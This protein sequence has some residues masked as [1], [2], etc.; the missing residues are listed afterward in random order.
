MNRGWLGFTRIPKSLYH[1]TPQG[2]TSTERRK[3]FRE[4][5]FC[6]G[7]RKLNPFSWWNLLVNIIVGEGTKPG[8]KLH[9]FVDRRKSRVKVL[10]CGPSCIPLFSRAAVSMVKI[11]REEY[12][13]WKRNSPLLYDL[14]LAHGLEWPSLTV[15]WLPCCQ[16]WVISLL[17][18]VES[19][20]SLSNDHV[21]H[22]LI[23]GTHTSRDEQ[24]FLM[25]ASV[26]VPHAPK[27]P[28]SKML[29][30]HEGGLSSNSCSHTHIGSKH[31]S[32]F[33]NIKIRILHQG[34]VN[35]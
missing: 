21:A 35:R 2:T 25:I 27:L 10:F 7:S 11:I 30:A 33:T 17:A 19:S 14:L 23:L 31:V 13:I 32:G 16:M 1:G 28:E 6:S 3:K 29:L 5:R 12:R 18:L 9:L 4:N 8:F 22:Q 24:N 15:Q 20:Y 26:V 34:E